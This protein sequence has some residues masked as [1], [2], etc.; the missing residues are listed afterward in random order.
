MDGKDA[1][2]GTMAGDRDRLTGLS[3][4][5]HAHPE[6]AWHEEKAA[7]WGSAELADRGFDVQ[8]GAC[9]LPTAFIARFGSG[10]LHIGICAEYDALPGVGH[11][12]GHNLIRAAAVGAGLALAAAADELGITVTVFGTPAE[13][14]GGGKVYMLERGAVTWV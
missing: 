12:R 6:T 4:R 8:T 11:A 14:G 9:D 7:A 10:P 2:A 13:E 1:I 5:L 3:H